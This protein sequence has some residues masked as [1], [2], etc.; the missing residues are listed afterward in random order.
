MEP[1]E[2]RSTVLPTPAE[3]AI[4][5]AFR[6]RTLLPLD[7]VMGCPRDQ[8]PKLARSSLPSC[9]E[10]HGISRLPAN[11]TMTKRGRFAETTKDASI[12]KI[13]PRHLIPGPNTTA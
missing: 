13:D 2:R 4:I 9:L 3:E 6:Q 12:F 1:R 7:D 10:R 8:S 11:E 5:V